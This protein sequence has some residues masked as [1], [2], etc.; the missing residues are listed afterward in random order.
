M[1][2]YNIPLV[3]IIS[4]DLPAIEERHVALVICEAVDEIVPRHVT[5]AQLRDSVWTIRLKSFEAKEHL[6]ENIKVLNI[7]NCKINIHEQYPTINTAVPSEKFLFKDIPFEISDDVLM[8]YV[9]SQPDIHVKTRNMIHARLRNKAGQLTPFHSGDR[10]IYVR[11]GFRRALPSVV[12][13][14][15]QRCRIFHH[16]QE[17]SCSRCRYIGHRIDDTASCEAYTNEQDIITIRSPKNPL[18][19]YYMCTISI[20]GHTFHSSEQAYQWKYTD[21]IGRNDLAQEILTTKTPEKAKEIASRVPRHMQ[22]DWHSIKIGIME[23][24]LLEK[25]KKCDDFKNSL[26]SSGEKKIVEAVK[27]DRHWSCGL[28]P[29]DATTTKPQF[30]PGE[31]R[32]GLLL[33]QI[34]STLS[35][36][37]N[38]PILKDGADQVTASKPDLR[39]SQLDTLP[40]PPQPS[41]LISPTS[42]PSTYEDIK[43]D[44]S[45]NTISPSN[46]EKTLISSLSQAELSVDVMTAES[47]NDAVSAN[48]IPSSRILTPRQAMSTT[49]TPKKKVTHI[50]KPERRIKSRTKLNNEGEE[51]LSNGKGNLM[52][53]WVKRK[54]SPEKEADC[55]STLKQSKQDT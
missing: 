29:K 12:D 40:L 50:K 35:G 43:S 32:L 44:R 28:N 14:D 23:E 22:K 51:Q 7:Q 19:N 17:Q 27:S 16:S 5:G 31:N 20:Y 34:R 4:N 18:C 49:T 1:A 33:E 15:H 41:C 45:A 8:D 6:I 53:S 3:Y 54:L 26:I 13:I 38:I 48:L 46:S 55:T 52:M 25:L 21:Y 24:I 39:S 47:T 30:Y 36:E 2:Y 37:N 10:F 42:L 11:G 9:Y